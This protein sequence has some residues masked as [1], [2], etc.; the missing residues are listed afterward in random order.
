[1]SGTEGWKDLIKDADSG[2]SVYINRV[3]KCFTGMDNKQTVNISMLLTALEGE[4]RS[5]FDLVIPDPKGAEPILFELCRRYLYAE[6][7]N[8]LSS[9]GGRMLEIFYDKA[10][11]SLDALCSSLDEAFGISLSRKDRP[12]YG[13][14]VNVIDRMLAALSSDNERFSFV[15]SDIS[16]LGN[17]LPVSSESGRE[18]GLV[19]FRRAAE[20]LEGKLLCGIDVGGT[21]IK[22]AVV[23]DGRVIAFK[24]YDWFP[25]VF[26]QSKQLVEPVV[27]LTRMLRNIFILTHVHDKV[28]VELK[29]RISEVL[30]RE[31]TES[32]MAAFCDDAEAFLKDHII[33][34]DGI[35]L[36]FPDVVIR[37][38]VVGGEVYKTRGIRN[39]PEIDYEDDFTSLTD[40]NVRLEQY[41]SKP[42]AVSMINDGPMAAFTAAVE[43]AASEKAPMVEKGVFAHTLGTELGTGWVREDG[44]IPDIPLEVYNF[45]IDLGCVPE[46]QY[47]PDDLR[48]VNNFNTGLS[49]T[50]QKYT[51]QSGVFRLA[52]KYFPAERPDLY[53]ELEEKGFVQEVQINGESRLIVP[54]EP[55]DM[56]K[57]FL[58]HMMMLAEREN[59]ETNRKIWLEIGAALGVTWLE[60][61]RIL[62]PAAKTRFQFG[63]LVKRKICYDLLLEGAKTVVPEIEFEIAD[64]TLANTSLMKQL[65]EDRDYTVAQF[66]QAVGAI[67]YANECLIRKGLA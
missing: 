45:I 14:C 39:N 35:G 22:L 56:R 7:Y 10:N 51:S 59:D 53:R 58:E 62:H 67:Y 66:A 40:L 57:A 3:R 12:G 37:D 29:V 34:F 43:M 65:E 5:R 32:E 48:S 64:S 27:L 15:Y 9:L 25:A 36:C 4:N 2:N 61:E 13:R 6:V 33:N 50:L 20:G 52:V 41:C 16:A 23:Y 17:P 60:T 21:D 24:E 19:I 11:R 55:E 26:K 28:P 30:R 1:M 47:H 54:T 49:G 44:T 46:Q 42:G 38:K 8:I 18:S 63:R 31:A